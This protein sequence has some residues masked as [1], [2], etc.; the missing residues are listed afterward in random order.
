MSSDPEKKI[1]RRLTS[2]AALVGLLFLVTGAPTACSGAVVGGECRFGLLECNGTCVDPNV[3]PDNCGQCGNVCASRQCVSGVCGVGGGA[4]SGGAAIDGG[5]GAGGI[6]AG[7]ASGSGGVG[8]GGL[9]G[10]SNGGSSG[11][12]SANGGASGDASVDGGG[13]DAS[14]NGG[15]GGD[16]SSNGGAGGDASANGGAGGGAGAGGTSSGGSGGVA[17]SGGSSSGG[18]SGMDG[19]GGTGGSSCVGHYDTPQQCGDCFTRCTGATPLC[20]PG[21][22]G[23]ICVPLCTAPLVDCAGQCVNTDN[24]ENNCGRCGHVCA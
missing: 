7:G 1:A 21:N 3:D 23:Y 9:G 16:A 10:T 6:G 8:T 24:D 4:G 5:S 20:A 14:A 12:A 17:G 19:G 18:S 2:A 13:R 11:D 15:A 22:D